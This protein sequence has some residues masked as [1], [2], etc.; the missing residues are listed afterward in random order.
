MLVNILIPVEIESVPNL[1]VLVSIIYNQFK[2]N[3]VSVFYL[4]VEFRPDGF[5]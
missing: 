2:F 5:K 1:K 3:V 4:F